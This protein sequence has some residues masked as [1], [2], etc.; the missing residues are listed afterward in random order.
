MNDSVI[1][2]PAAK[3][4]RSKQQKKETTAKMTKSVGKNQS[5]WLDSLKE[6]ITKLK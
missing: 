5:V 3:K 6:E 4:K 2:R 1:N